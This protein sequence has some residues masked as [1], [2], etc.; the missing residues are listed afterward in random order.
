MRKLLDKA[1][2]EQKIYAINGISLF[3]PHAEISFWVSFP[4]KVLPSKSCPDAEAYWPHV[5]RSGVKTIQARE[6]KTLSI[7]ISK[8]FVL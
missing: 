5:H 4:F 7:K 2:A 8:F 1:F 3:P 6:K